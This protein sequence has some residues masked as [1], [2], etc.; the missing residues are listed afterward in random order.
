MKEITSVS[1]PQV[2]AWKNLPLKGAS[3]KPNLSTRWLAFS[4]R[5]IEFW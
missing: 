2:K 1:N 5:G 3:T 4:Q